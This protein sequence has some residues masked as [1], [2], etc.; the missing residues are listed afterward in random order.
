MLVFDFC[1]E[2]WY[3]NYRKDRKR[4]NKQLILTTKQEEVLKI[5]VQRYK[6]REAFTCISGYAG[7]GKSTIVRFIIAALNLNLDDVVYV[8][9]T[10]KASLVLKE[11]GNDNVMTAH[12]LLYKSYPKPDGTFIHMPKKYLDRPY[13]LI[14]VDEVSMLPKEMWDLLLSHHIHVIALGDPGQLPPIGG[15]N[16][17]L[18]RPHVFLDEIIRQ[19]QES[20]IIRLSMGIREGK[21]ITSFQGNEVQVLNKNDLNTGLLTWADQILVAK[22]DTRSYINTQMRDILGHGNEPEVD[23]K[24]ICLKNNW[25]IVSDSGDALVNGSLGIIKTIRLIKKPIIGKVYVITFDT[26]GSSGEYY[27]ILCDYKLFNEGVKTLS[28]GSYLSRRTPLNIKP[29]EFDYGYALTTWKAQGSEWDKVLL[30]EENFPFGKEE[31]KR[32][33]YTSVTRAKN[34]LVIIQNS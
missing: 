2:I 15:D 20:E 6:A 3:N 17:I 25:N 14:V 9:Y 22:N 33:L 24:I 32:F 21:P 13:K 34:K 5:A 7:T 16:K 1:I 27:D 26:E 29:N 4:G 19:A 23:D 18:Q 28:H 8:S 31:R 12:K 30:I 10:G 11:K